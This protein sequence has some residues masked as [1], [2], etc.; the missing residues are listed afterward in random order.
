ME[1]IQ[2]G[3]MC[4]RV[5]GVMLAAV[6]LGDGAVSAQV[7]IVNTGSVAG[8]PGGKPMPLVNAD[9]E[10]AAFLEKA[11]EHIDRKTYDKAIEILQ[12]L[13][14]RPDSGFIPAP[15]G[16]RYVSLWLIANERIGAMPPEGLKLYRMLYDPQSGQLQKEW[17]EGG[18]IARLRRIVRR[19]LHTTHGPEA[20]E[21][22][23]SHYFDRGQFYQAVRYWRYLLRVRPDREAAL[24]M[25][26]M[27]AAYHLVGDDKEAGK[28]ATE[29]R[30]EHA[31]A[32][33]RI[34]GEDRNLAQFVAEVR[35]LPAMRVRRRIVTEG[36]PGLGGMPTGLWTMSDCDVVL[37]PR[38]RRPD[39]A[40]ASVS[41]SQ[42]IVAIPSLTMAVSN[43]RYKISVRVRDGR[44]LVKSPQMGNKEQPLPSMVH[45]VVADELVI[46][47][48]SE[49]V[50]AYDMITGELKWQS[51]R[52]PLYRKAAA[53]TTN[54]YYGG[55]PIAL[56][57]RG[58]YRLTV[59]GGQIFALHGFRPTNHYPYYMNR[60]GQT[61]EPDTSALSA[62]SLEAQGRLS[63]TIGNGQGDDDLI[64]NGKF[65]AAPTYSAGR[66]YAIVL[67]LEGYHLVCLDA[68]NRGRLIWKAMIA[69]TPAVQTRYGYTPASQLL[70]LGSPP[71]V[72]EGRVFV[73]T[74]AGVVAGF[75]AGTGQA[76]WA[77]QY[78]TDFDLRA[79]GRQNVYAPQRGGV[80]S[81]GPNP[82]IVVRGR[83]ICLP[84]DSQ[85]VL[86]LS[87]DDGGFLW[88]ADR[89]GQQ[90]L[91]ALDEGRI[92]LSGQALRVLSTNDGK[93]LAHPEHVKDVSGRPAVTRTEVLASGAGKLYR[94]DLSTYAV[95]TIDLTGA[96]GL[97]GNLI[98]VDGK[99][100]AANGLGV[101][102]YF[103]YDE[104]RD[105]L[106]ERLDRAA[107]DAKLGLLLQRAQLAFNARRFPAALADLKSGER[108]L[109]DPQGGAPAL[110]EYRPW[111]HRTYI[112]L[113][114]TTDTSDRMREMF[115]A[116]T[117]YAETTQ[118]QAHMKLRMAKYR[119]RVADETS[120]DERLAHLRVAAALAQE[121][122]ETYGEE[123][124][125]DARI[126][127]DADHSVRFPPDRQR[128]LG[129]VLAQ[130]FI[131]RKLIE[132]NGQDVYSEFDAK[133]RTALDGAV[134]IDDA[135]AMTAISDRYRYSKF[136]DDA[137]FASAESWYRKA[138]QATG[139]EAA[140]PLGRAIGLLS[141]VAHM[142]GSP[143]AVSA[144]LA[145]AVIH[146]RSGMTI[147]A[148]VE[149]AHLRS[150]PAGT[151]VAFA[152]IRGTL[153][154]LLKKIEGGQ[155]TVR[156]VTVPLLSMIPVPLVEI[157]AAGKGDAYILRDQE[158]RPLRVGQSLFVLRGD[159]VVMLNTSG[160]DAESAVQWIGMTG[161][162]K[163]ALARYS[164]MPGFRLLGALSRDRR[165][166]LVADR[167]QI[168]ALD[169]ETG[170]AK[171][172]KKMTDVGVK[173]FVC[174][175]TGQNVLIATDN[176]GQLVCLEMISGEVRWKAKVEG[177]GYRALSGPPRI[178]PTV[179][180]TR[181]NNFRGM[182]CY[183]L[184]TGKAM[185]TW[186][187]RSL[188]EGRITPEGLL[189]ILVDGKLSILEVNRISKPLWDPVVFDL[190]KQ[191]SILAVSS[192]RIVVSPDF[193]SGEVQV[194]SITGGGRAVAK[195]TVGKANTAAAFP[196][197]AEFG[198]RGR[199]IY[200]TNTLAATGNRGRY[201]GRL[202]YSR[203]L[204]LQKF[205]LA[206]QQIVW[207]VTLDE[208]PNSYYYTV[209]ITI[210]RRHLVVSARQNRWNQPSW[211]YVVD[212]EAGTIREKMQMHDGK[213]DASTVSRR[214]QSIGPAVMT[215]GRL[216]V[217]SIG[218]VKVYG[219]Q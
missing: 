203:G 149:C 184:R 62:W 160:R 51:H 35:A 216:C 85:H 12:A 58:R 27:A 155:I 49:A 105:R 76:L 201:F 94:M 32:T 59:G 154:E 192:D 120:G 206:R 13:I 164:S 204:N 5:I 198:P 104:A 107:A 46:L 36:W 211:Y 10:L 42:L 138:L 115:E 150:L 146:Y 7:L 50:S 28:L 162:D 113:G 24:V 134:S 191:P 125:V 6:L 128:I 185:A 95:G 178:G 40:G 207:N 71:A 33:A 133:A 60:A 142:D 65:L 92:L 18:D 8:P 175:S 215:N 64:R 129:K 103:S 31:E 208:T 127:A 90:D 9:E 97:L 109:R 110:G 183:D 121:I 53:Q 151:P 4:C 152:D 156:P 212:S 77:W 61:S 181:Y 219:R 34:A 144:R 101:C 86:A 112:A 45:P 165:T 22:L 167:T 141:S 54:R 171:W 70:D 147:A 170:K 93:V 52:A 106:S 108:A 210:G 172:Q 195:F 140:E 153:G 111:L 41:A 2:I 96:D 37:A 126:G 75:D 130:D 132:K 72:A 124:L 66:L 100:I 214:L 174:M 135:E 173:N 74:N 186:T 190:A 3:P 80:V 91:T 118:E 116:A 11:Q 197:A 161:I 55:Y 180:L 102:A 17:R 176:T 193:R 209:P 30:R 200:V 188:L 139:E 157:F 143:L 98:S 63:W 122:S 38:W 89:G 14:N 82:V 114:N 218:A 29:L 119:Q 136:A 99:L 158:Y 166:L 202:S 189:V 21:A 187:G 205:D 43:P 15:N 163:A 73:T 87:A 57:D 88:Q 123:K 20:L 131:I 25:A 67:Y 16:R 83:V 69:Q 169:V 78:D 182:A 196:V 217:E 179:V 68:E 148:R 213:G 47:R 23:G 199:A 168:V 26:K 56:A 159:Q 81:R 137:L 79:R 48:T 39:N 194:L 177:R 117:G 1:S 44:V 145:S 84:A 19:Y